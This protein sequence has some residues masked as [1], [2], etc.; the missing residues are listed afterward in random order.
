MAEHGILPVQP[1]HV[2]SL[3]LIITEKQIRK[4]RFAYDA[5]PKFRHLTYK[6]IMATFSFRSMRRRGYVLTIVDP[7]GYP[8]SVSG[9]R[10]LCTGHPTSTSRSWRSRG[11]S[12]R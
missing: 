7:T 11:R 10:Q 8:I 5:F 1:E 12:S 3:E 2:M 9:R 6:D 4:G